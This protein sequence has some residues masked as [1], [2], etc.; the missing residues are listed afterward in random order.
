[1]AALPRFSPRRAYT[2]LALAALL[3]LGA[4]GGGGGGTKDNPATA[5]AS[6]TAAKGLIRYAE[7]TAYQIDGGVEKQ[8][9]ATTYTDE[10][11]RYTLTGLPVGVVVVL[12]IKAVAAA[13][14]RPASEMVDEATDDVIALPAGSLELRAA[15]VLE[16]SSGGS[17]NSLHITPFS[18]MAVA[19]AVNATGGLTS[20]NVTAANADL[21]AFL[22]FNPLID[23]PTF[24]AA[25]GSDQ[26]GKPTNQ[27]ALMLAAV[28]ELAA[29]SGL[30]CAQTLPLDRV[31]CVFAEFNDLGTHSSVIASALNA[32]K[33]AAV[34]NE[35][36]GGTPNQ[37]IPP[38]VQVQP[39]VLVPVPQR[40]A[41]QSAKA[42]IQ[43]VRANAEPLQQ[44][45]EKL[46]GVQSTLVEALSP[47]SPGR[48]ALIQ[49]QVTAVDYLDRLAQGQ[50]SGDLPVPAGDLIQPVVRDVIGAGCTVYA[51]EGL[52]TLATTYENADYAVCR[53]TYAD[54]IEGDR[55]YLYQQRFSVSPNAAAG[56]RAYTVTSAVIKQEIRLSPIGSWV[57]NPVN[58]IG[59]PVVQSDYHDLEVVATG[60][61][62]NITALAL[63][64]DLPESVGPDGGLTAETLTINLNLS[65]AALTDGSGL[66]RLSLVGLLSTV[67]ADTDEEIATVGLASG[68]YV[69]ARL[70]TP[71]IVNS[72]VV[73][74]VGSK[75]HFVLQATVNGGSQVT[76]TLDVSDYGTSRGGDEWPTKAVFAGQ[77]K[78]DAQTLLF[79]GN[80]TLTVSG[81]G[82]FD[83]RLPGSDNSADNFLPKQV[84]FDGTLYAPGVQALALNISLNNATFG[85]VAGSGSLVQGGRVIN[86]VAQYNQTT[87]A[88]TATLS[89]T[90]G[91]SVTLSTANPTSQITANGGVVVGTVNSNTGRI[92][93]ADGTFESF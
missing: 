26:P 67:S 93:Y 56:S 37:V 12:K 11:G 50:A 20:T 41:V 91:L 23:A 79:S 19:K 48:L 2:P 40:N 22:H 84:L 86:I 64:G 81:L 42:L 89:S 9:G 38:N 87:G 28:S 25:T 36:Y 65:A 13:G 68:S 74:N 75:G 71:G 30:G 63:N 54:V 14:G 66:S 90:D 8:V 80:V 59:N 70:A 34:T 78:E 1:M 31:K 46:S 15:T 49:A 10:N 88:S 24:E 45:G 44:L 3:A 60:S 83:P 77:I 52:Q 32:A 6:G 5:T 69:E 76:G 35:G 85:S 29:S 57:G 7:V 82:S 62:N 72:N 43:S 17:V 39:E 55:R 33:D 18:D 73:N 16:A 47:L 53:V 51:D 21:A 92:D 61:G 4:C 27:A 58:R